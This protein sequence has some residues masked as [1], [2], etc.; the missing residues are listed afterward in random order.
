MKL[1]A[2]ETERLRRSLEECG[3]MARRHSRDHSSEIHSEI[4]KLYRYLNNLVQGLPPKGAAP[5]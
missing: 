5:R 2:E 1:D 3:R 4:L